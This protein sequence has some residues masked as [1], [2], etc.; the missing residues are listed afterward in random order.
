MF[1]LGQE[2]TPESVRRI[3]T[4]TKGLDISIVINNAGVAINEWLMNTD[5]IKGNQLLNL[6]DLSLMLIMKLML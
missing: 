2:S 4:E 3:D 5:P 6:N 1:D